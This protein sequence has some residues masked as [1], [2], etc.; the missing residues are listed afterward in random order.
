MATGGKMHTEIFVFV[1][2]DQLKYQFVWVLGEHNSLSMT[3]IEKK[4]HLMGICDVCMFYL[5]QLYADRKR[6][7][8]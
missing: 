8:M 4:L 5:F 2:P 3:Q 6:V 1:I 7:A